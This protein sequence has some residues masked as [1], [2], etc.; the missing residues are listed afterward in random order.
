MMKAI[1]T[2]LAFDFGASSGRAICCHFDGTKLELQEVHRFLNEPVA[3]NGILYWNL[4]TLFQ[5]VLTGI[6][7]AQDAGGFDSIGVDTWGVDFG[8]LD[9]NGEILEAPVHYRDGRTNG[10]S[11][12]VCSMVGE[13]EL[14]E[15]T[16]T[17]R[18]DINTI[19][20]LYALRKYRPDFLAKAK[21]LLL[22][23]DL[24]NYLL[25]GE[26]H[27]EHTIAS[28]TQML[29]LNSKTWNNPLLKKLGLPQDIL[30]EP[31]VPGTI[32]GVLKEDICKKLG[33]SSVPVVAVA[34]HDT[35]SAVMAVPAT[36]EK[37]IF[38]SCGTW[39]LFGTECKE[40]VINEHS[41]N[42]NLTNELGFGSSVTFLK[43][44]IGLWLI[45]ETRRQ[46]MR[47]GRE[48]T[49]AQMEEM[50][51]K[52]R[53]FTCFIDPDA[54]EFVPTGDIPGRVRE[55]CKKTGQAIPETE[56]EI[57]RCIYESLAMK[58]R[59]VFEQ[60]KSCTNESYKAIHL[61]GGG[62]K[63]SFLCQMTANA[64]NVLVVAGPI[65][66]TAMGNAAA[67]LVALGKLSN[68]EQARSVIRSSFEPLEYLPTE[69]ELWSQQYLKIQKF[70]R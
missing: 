33:V 65:E 66:A 10:L 45:Q 60:I 48:Y 53:P 11:D 12:K 15:M 5:E 8:L 16:G 23:P 55:F 35:A 56:G 63:D 47:D 51:R 39:S 9:E 34:S 21:S 42:C 69:S 70:F 13:R 50:A 68:L 67:Q 1:T 49:Y 19:F 36:E 3:Q 37:F 38:I 29:N 41:K 44:I 46:F 18:M 2:A 4:D 28:T 27:A 7:K 22:M 20:Q 64:A 14:Y 43:N 52:S 26:R 25:T 30:P 62:A 40:P 6:K 24:F 59:F 57:I 58:Y 54:P 61:V 32:A 31:I 17:Q